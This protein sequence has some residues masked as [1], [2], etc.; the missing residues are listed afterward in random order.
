MSPATERPIVVSDDDRAEAQ[1]S[2]SA[3]ARS[4]TIGG[5]SGA[6]L[7]VAVAVLLANAIAPGLAGAARALVTAGV[8]A[9]L[10]APLLIFV[11][12]RAKRAGV[13]DGAERVARERA[14]KEESRQREFA[15]RL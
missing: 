4:A 7:T 9:V 5:I 10:V 3:Q 14:L 15:T 11:A 1:A 6:I 13:R 12:A 2:V 8:A